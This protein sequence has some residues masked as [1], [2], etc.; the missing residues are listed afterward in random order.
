MNDPV[1]V[2][3]KLSPNWRW[4]FGDLA[5]TTFP[6]LQGKRRQ[7]ILAI[8]KVPGNSGQMR[9]HFR[10]QTYLQTAILNPMAVYPG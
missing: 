3:L 9:V 4:S 1:P 10:S 8:L 5:P 6:A 2:T 7:G